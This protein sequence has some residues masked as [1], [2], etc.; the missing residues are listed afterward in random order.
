M[1]KKIVSLTLCAVLF[2]SGCSSSKQVAVAYNGGSS[3]VQ[4]YFTKNNDQPEKAL[5]NV[6]NSSRSSLDL[7][8]YDITKEDIV[9]AVL[10]AKKRGIQVRVITDKVESN[11]KSESGVLEI[12]KENG[13]QVKVNSHSGL[14]HMK[15]TIVDNNI[16]TTGSYNYT[17]QASTKNDEVLVVLKDSSSAKDFEDQFEKMWDD[18]NDFQDY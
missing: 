11:T 5:I 16:V 14:M 1:Y 10:Y 13:I 15:V 4:Y 18:N 12:F 7:A 3:M 17:A 9:K 6:I 2:L 8:I